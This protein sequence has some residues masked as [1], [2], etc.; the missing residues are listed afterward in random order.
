MAITDNA[1]EYNN[2]ELLFDM[3]QSNY[4]ALKD[5]EGDLQLLKNLWDGILLVKETFL[6][7]NSTLWDKI[8][9][10]Q[11]LMRVKELQTQV[12]NMPKGMRGWPLYSWLLDEVKNM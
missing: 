12:K 2:L 10:D 7:W 8:D 11:L 3:V 4:R 5:S 9:T 6:N 1:K